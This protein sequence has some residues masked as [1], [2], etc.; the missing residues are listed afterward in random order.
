MY[1]KQRYVYCYQLFQYFKHNNS[2]SSMRR[3]FEQSLPFPAQHALKNLGE[4]LREARLVR[5]MSMADMCERAFIS[6]STL[7]KIERGDP[8]VALGYYASVLFILQLHQGLAKL[9]DL[10]SD[11]LGLALTLEQLPKR[12]RKPRPP[13]P[14][15]KD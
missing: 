2:T 15:T 12:I 9:A 3:Q 14:T 6:R 5:R 8:S 1:N 4:G 13:L 7:H 11:E 10:S